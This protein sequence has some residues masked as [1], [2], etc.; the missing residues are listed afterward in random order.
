M[1]VRL[2]SFNK[3]KHQEKTNERKQDIYINVPHMDEENMYYMY[4]HYIN[5]V[6]CSILNSNV[7]CLV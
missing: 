1:C 7:M 2:K 6:F 5:K 4:K 3:T